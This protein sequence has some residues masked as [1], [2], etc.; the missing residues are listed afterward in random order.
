MKRLKVCLLLVAA[1]WAAAAAAS[2]AYASD[3]L[4]PVRVDAEGRYIDV[5]AGNAAPFVGDFDG[6]GVFDLLVGQRAQCKLLIFHNTG[7]NKSP[8]FGGSTFLKAAGVE[9]SL[10]GG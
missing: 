10:P 7:S 6:D 4:P 8:R 5:Q 3:L 9:A 1:S 2:P